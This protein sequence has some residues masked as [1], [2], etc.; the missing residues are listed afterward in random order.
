MSFVDLSHSFEDGMPGFRME[1]ED[2]TVTEYTAEIQPFFTHEESESFY[3][4][5]SAFEVTEVTFQTSV[6]TYLDSP[7]HRYPDGRDIGD[8]DIDELVLPG[9]VVDARGLKPYDELGVN[10][11]PTDRNLEN[12]AV[13][14]N[15]GWDDHWGTE[16][17]RSYPYI[18][19]ALIDRLI[20]ENVGLVG[21]DT[22]NIDDHRNPSR[23]AHTRFLDEEIYIVE[24]MT[25]LDALFEDSFRLFAVPIKATQTAAMPI[26][27]FAELP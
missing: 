25:G 10:A 13:L 15:F 11:L 18:S 5:E 7:Y 21:V 2:G 9:V 19:D 3:D 16:T 12:R 6:G 20:D 22:I 4:G 17:Y 8:L 24:N 26:R 1:D 27:A 23:P 14:F